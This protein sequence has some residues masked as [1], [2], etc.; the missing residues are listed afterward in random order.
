MV[1]EIFLFK[2]VA[3]ACKGQVPGSL[4]CVQQLRT[5]H[6][7]GGMCWGERQVQV[8]HPSQAKTNLTRAHP[9][10]R[11]STPAIAFVIFQNSY[12]KIYIFFQLKDVSI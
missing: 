7:H 3:L 2:L 4:F 8:T 9:A 11:C 10:A 5:V 6:P 1:F 12:I